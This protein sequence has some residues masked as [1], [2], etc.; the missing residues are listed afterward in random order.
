MHPAFRKYGILMVAVC[1]V[2]SLSYFKTSSKKVAT[3]SKTSTVAENRTDDEKPKQS[4]A[5]TVATQP[6]KLHRPDFTKAA[7]PATEQPPEQPPEQPEQPTEQIE[8]IRFA[9]GA[10]AEQVNESLAEYESRNPLKVHTA[11]VLVLDKGHRRRIVLNSLKPKFDK[12]QYE[13]ACEILDQNKHEFDDL[14]QRRYQIM[15]HDD[16]SKIPEMLRYNDIAVR[17]LCRNLTG[18][19]F[20]AVIRQTESPQERRA[21]MRNAGFKVQRN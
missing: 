7:E 1:L 15:S 2:I 14:L 4:N 5:E 13:L 11:L 21:R 17:L 3:Q 12:Q 8:L 9:T 6:A 18:K 10:I 19:I 20:T 16:R